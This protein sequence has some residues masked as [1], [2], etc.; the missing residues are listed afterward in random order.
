MVSSIFRN[1]IEQT[2]LRW[3]VRIFESSVPRVRPNNKLHK[4]MKEFQENVEL[5]TLASPIIDP[6][7]STT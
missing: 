3:N 2:L 5:N 4:R 6:E 1:F 7:S